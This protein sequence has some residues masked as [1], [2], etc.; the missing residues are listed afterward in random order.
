MRRTPHPLFCA[1]CGVWIT[2]GQHF[3]CCRRLRSTLDPD[4]DPDPEHD[5][6]EDKDYDDETEAMT[7]QLID[8]LRG[9]G[10][11]TTTCD[12]PWAYGRDMNL[13]PRC[14][15]YLKVDFN[16]AGWVG[17]DGKWWE[18]TPKRAVWR[19]ELVL[20]ERLSPWIS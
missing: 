8:Q 11:S 16:Q 10:F 19:V 7:A 14:S 9:Q 4:P 1:G 6:D 3:E 12:I 20:R 15:L 2:Y 18:G 13:C 17:P 5:P